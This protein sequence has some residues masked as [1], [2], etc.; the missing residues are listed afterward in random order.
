MM[1]AGQH[2][3]RPVNPVGI[4]IPGEHSVAG[5]QDP[6]A[7]GPRQA[8]GFTRQGDAIGRAKMPIDQGA[9]RRQVSSEGEGV[10]LAFRVGEGKQGWCH[11]TIFAADTRGRACHLSR[12]IVGRRHD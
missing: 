1:G 12:C 4:A 2:A 7:T 5:N 8:H 9:A 3:F 10:G 6:H 11:G